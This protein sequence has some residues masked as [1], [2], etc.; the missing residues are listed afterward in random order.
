[1]LRGMPGSRPLFLALLLPL[2][3]LACGDDPGIDDALVPSSPGPDE[4]PVA[5][6]ADDAGAAAPAS[7]ATPSPSPSTPTATPN[8]DG[9]YVVAC[10]DIHVPLD[11]VHR[12]PEDCEPEGLQPVAETY[13]YGP[14]SV[15][16]FVIPDLL[17][18]LDA[19]AAAG[20][21]LAVVSTYRSYETQRATFQYHV[22]SLGLD[23]ALRV[24]ARAGHSEHQ[25]GTTVDFSSSAV[26]FE[27]VQEFGNTPEGAWLAER[28]HEFGF[29]LSYPEG[30]EHVTGYAYEPWHFRW[31]GREKAAEVRASGLTLGQFLLR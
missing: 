15:V 8:A 12:L 21:G 19:A 14:Q 24:S 29:V 16:Q 11:K 10:G 7:T 17:A 2:L 23:E 26:G 4:T 28:A 31:V 18:L 20:H 13:A 6:T 5:A 3:I 30:L 9:V 1:M 22:D 27:L 25:L